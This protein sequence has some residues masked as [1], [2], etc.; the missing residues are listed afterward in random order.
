MAT[1]V[2]ATYTIS[3]VWN[4]DEILEELQIDAASLESHYVKWDKLFLTYIDA[5]G[6]EVEVE[7]EPNRANASRD[8]DWKSPSVEETIED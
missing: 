6:E 3:S 1:Y 2:Y 5:D 7:Y 4:L 8:F